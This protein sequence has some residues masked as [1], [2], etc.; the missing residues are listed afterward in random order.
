MLFLIY[1]LKRNLNKPPVETFI[2]FFMN[3]CF[4]SYYLF[5]RHAASQAT[6]QH[7]INFDNQHHIN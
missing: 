2:N 1:P 6:D 5:T 7:L 4:L 3:I